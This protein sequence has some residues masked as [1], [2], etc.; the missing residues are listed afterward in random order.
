MLA[1]PG[2]GR[3]INNGSVCAQ[4]PCHNSIA[5]TAIQHGL[6]KSTS[7]DGRELNI[8]C[9]QIDVGDIESEIARRLG[10]TGARINTVPCWTHGWRRRR[11]CKERPLRSQWTHRRVST[12]SC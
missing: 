3:I 6:T 9:G 5:Y 10:A 4:V 7:P 2:G 11:C 1:C 12:S 8:A